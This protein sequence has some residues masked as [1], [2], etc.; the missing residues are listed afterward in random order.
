YSENQNKRGTLPSHRE[1]KDKVQW[2]LKWNISSQSFRSS[3]Q[4][5]YIG[6]IARDK[7]SQISTVCHSC[8]IS[9]LFLFQE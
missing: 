4:P 1:Q 5:E 8:L 7:T 6:A 9:T 2:C 3:A